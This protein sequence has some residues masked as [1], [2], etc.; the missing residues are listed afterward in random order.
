MT[1]NPAFE[2]TS[3]SVAPRDALRHA[4]SRGATLVA[5]AQLVRWAVPASRLL[6]Q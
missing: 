6:T 4:A 2:G 5:A 1:P 3:T